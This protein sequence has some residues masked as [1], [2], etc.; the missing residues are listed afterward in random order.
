MVAET[1]RACG[2][3][4]EL[5]PTDKLLVGVHYRVS[6]G[7]PG[8]K[9]PWVLD[10]LMMTMALFAL[11][12][13]S[14]GD[15][16]GFNSPCGAYVTCQIYQLF[17]NLK[18]SI[19][20]FKMICGFAWCGND[21]YVSRDISVLGAVS[22]GIFTACLLEDAVAVVLAIQELMNQKTVV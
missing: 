21:L 22:R 2:G 9:T 20:S 17:S 10:G 6:G 13:V 3:K 5:T 16:S 19:N 18:P 11:Q 8:V 15:A 14:K 12:S 4:G 1:H 7:L